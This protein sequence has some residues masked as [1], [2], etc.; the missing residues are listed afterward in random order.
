MFKSSFISTQISRWQRYG[1]DHGIGFM[2]NDVIRER[3]IDKSMYTAHYEYNNRV[4]S[5]T[6]IGFRIPLYVNFRKTL[7][8][9]PHFVW[10]DHCGFIDAILVDQYGTTQ[11][12]FMTI[13]GEPSKRYWK[14]HGWHCSSETLDEENLRLLYEYIHER[15]KD[16]E[17]LPPNLECSEETGFLLK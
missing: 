11:F 8:I 17:V 2:L 9:S 13:E 7:D 4:F 16:L 10:W 12:H 1:L 3:G 15:I 6:H 5:E 14:N